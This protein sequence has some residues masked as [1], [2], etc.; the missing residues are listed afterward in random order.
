MAQ[1]KA[2]CLV[3]ARPPAQSQHL[4]A[5]TPALKGSAPSYSGLKL[6]TLSPHQQA[7]QN[8]E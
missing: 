7:K 4:Q 1:V 5:P 6:S 2:T 8:K 3:C